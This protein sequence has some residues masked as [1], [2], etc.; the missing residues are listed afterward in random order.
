LKREQERIFIKAGGKSKQ[1]IVEQDS[2]EDGLVTPFFDFAEALN[3]Y[4][5]NTYHRRAINLKASLLSNVEDGSKLEGAVPRS[6]KQFL[7]SV[8]TE[9]EIY[10]NSFIETAGS[11]LYIIRAQYARVDL[12]GR[13][14]QYKDSR[15]IALEGRQLS[16]YSPRSDFYGEP[17]YL[18]TMQM[19]G[20]NNKIDT[21]NE[22][23]FDNGARPEQAIIFE[24]AEPSEEQQRAFA[25]FF[26]KQFKGYQNAHKTLVI[27]AHGEQAK[28]RIED[29]SKINDI[30]FE[31]FKLLTRD[32]IIAAHGVPP[33]MVGVAEAGGLGGG[34]E[35]IGQLHAFNELT[36]VPKQEE[37]EWF[38]ESIGYPVKL[39]PIDVSSY[40]DDAELVSSLLSSGV[41]TIPEARRTL[42]LSGGVK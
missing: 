35:L 25:Q 41:I 36:I 15:K 20:I 13:I 7:R 16:Y 32:E 26:G 42:G 28:V 31:K 29:L 4:Y 21:F 9:A 11:M 2:V 39:K 8:I 34:G 3:F 23:Y 10:G 38:F 17:D 30:S 24:N 1:I 33:R 14:Y 37:I 12:Q 5:S 40:K 6:P 27:T 19:I 22:L 18:A